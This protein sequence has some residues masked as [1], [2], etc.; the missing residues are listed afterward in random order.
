VIGAKSLIDLEEALFRVVM[1]C[2]GRRPF[3]D[4][5]LLP[6]LTVLGVFAPLQRL[7]VL[8]RR[9]LAIVLLVVTAAIWLGGISGARRNISKICLAQIAETI[10]IMRSFTP[11]LYLPPPV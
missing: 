1:S 11:L 2:C 9:G 5:A 3:R 10:M 4:T 8:I 7:L 6:L